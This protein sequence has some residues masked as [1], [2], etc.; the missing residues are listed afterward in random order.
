MPVERHADWGRPGD[1]PADLEW[2][3]DDAS[4]ARSIAALRARGVTGI[5]VGLSAGDMV[6]TLGR[7]SSPVCYRLDVLDVRLVTRDGP[8]TVLA[9]AHVIEDRPRRSPLRR[10][11]RPPASVPP[12]ARY[13]MNAEF[14]GD[15]DVAPRGHP[16]DGRC[17]VVDFAPSM[18]TRQRRQAVDRMR[19]GD[20]LPHPDI[21][22]RRVGEE[23]WEP[24]GAVFVDGR[25]VLGV[26]SIV[27]TVVPDAII[28]WVG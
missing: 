1:P 6:R 15:L 20:H 8:R 24:S 18:P 3:A 21:S 22:V 23:N 4:A 12:A 26:S 19:R 9:L 27:V 2:F 5:E 11:L 25:P 10:L 28:A 13:V 7:G 16:N 14:V 17:E